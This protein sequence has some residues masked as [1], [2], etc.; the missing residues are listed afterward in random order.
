M[1][2]AVF[3]SAGRPLSI[4]EVPDPIPR[5]TEI[6][7]QVK[8][9]GI[10]GTD[11]HMSENVNPDG[12]WRLLKPGCILGHEFSGEIVEVGKDVSKD[13]QIGDRVTALPWIGCGDCYVCKIGRPYRCDLAMMRGSLELPG[14]YSEFCRI[15][16]SEVIRLPDEVNYSLGALIEPLAVGF[17]A[18][19]RAEISG[20]ETILI[21]GSGPVGLSITMWCQ[22]YGVKHILISDLVESRARAALN[23]GADSMIIPKQGNEIEEIYDCVGELPSVIFDCVGALGSMQMAIDYIL[24]GGKVIVVGLCMEKDYY[25]PA[26]ALLKEVD[27]RFSYVYCHDDFK[28]VADL[29]KRN[30]I[31]PRSLV[32][33]TINLLELPKVFEDLKVSSE[34]L[35][36]MLNFGSL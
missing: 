28:L 26:K 11:L 13:W 9:C 12:G 5:L 35:K 15:G 16:S 17:S 31:N 20:D 14:A 1:K 4:E 23:L 18:V 24:P 19:R 21:I 30:Q 22:F 10:C 3:H 32:S 8:A 33:Q 34:Q 27:I 29:L 36:V 7:L 2:A 25:F 6:L